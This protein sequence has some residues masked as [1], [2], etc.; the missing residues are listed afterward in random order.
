M[1]RVA[2]SIMCLL[3]LAA[4]SDVSNGG[5][6]ASVRETGTVTHDFG[7]Y[8]LEAGEEV[9]SKCVQWTLGNDEP[10]YVNSVTLSNR[11]AYHHSN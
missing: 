8:A 7:E 9:A 6:A 2:L 4:C 1:R 11:G 10:L 3:A 5:P